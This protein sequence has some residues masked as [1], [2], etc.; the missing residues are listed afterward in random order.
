VNAPKHLICIECGATFTDPRLAEL[1]TFNPPTKRNPSLYT[2]KKRHVIFPVSGRG[3]H[4]RGPIVPAGIDPGQAVPS[5]ECG[6]PLPPPVT[7]RQVSPENCTYGGIAAA[8]YL[9]EK[10]ETQA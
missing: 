9:H 4:T 10:K 5:R 3:W 6:T 1:H 8:G 7:F 2:Q